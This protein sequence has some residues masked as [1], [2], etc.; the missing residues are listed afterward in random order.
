MEESFKNFPYMQV[1]I[2]RQFLLCS[3]HTVSPFAL[4]LF[5]K[6]TNQNSFHSQKTV[7]TRYFKISISHFSGT[8]HDQK[9]KVSLG[10]GE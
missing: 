3:H 1:G 7:S 5:Y 10:F 4:Q 6:K 2:F 8:T 9:A